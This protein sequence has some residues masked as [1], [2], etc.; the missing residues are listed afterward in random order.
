VL[1]RL[2]HYDDRVLD[3]VSQWKRFQDDD[4]KTAECI[5]FVYKVRLSLIQH[6]F[7]V[8]GLTRL[9]IHSP[10]STDVYVSSGTLFRPHRRQS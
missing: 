2:L 4:D 6:I 5:K 8:V 3:L 10:H 1:C 7:V 9:L